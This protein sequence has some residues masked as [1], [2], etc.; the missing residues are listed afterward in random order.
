MNRRAGGQSDS[1]GKSRSPVSARMRWL[2]LLLALLPVLLVVRL[3]YEQNDFV[4]SVE[5]RTY[6][7]RFKTLRGPVAAHPGVA[8]IAV[9]DKSIAAL[10]RF[11]WTRKEYVRLLEALERA[12]PKVVLFDAFFPEP[13]SADADRAFA[14]ALQKAGNVVLATAFDFDRD[15]NVTGATRSLPQFEESAAAAHINLVPEDDGVNRRNLLAI[16]H[17]GE[18]VPSLGFMAALRALDVQDVRPGSDGSFELLDG[19]GKVLRRVPVTPDGAVWINYAGGAGVYE[20]ISFVD[21]VEGRFD[22][23]QLAGKAVFVGATALGIYDMRVT[24]FSVNA[25][26][27]E[28]HAAVAD[29]ILSSRVMERGSREA[30]FDLAAIVLL[31]LLCSA[32]AMRLRL[33]YA[34]V[35]V[36]GFVAL[37]FALA[38]KLFAEGQWVSMV[39]PAMA[40]LATLMTGGA[41]RFMVIERNARQMRAMF[42]TY[43]SNKLVGQLEQNPDAARLG[44]DTREVTVMFTDIKGFTTFSERHPP[45]V[46][47]ERL[48]EYLGAMVQI[49]HRHDGTVDKFMGDGILAY[50]GAPLPQDGH[51]QLALSCALAMRE[52]MRK[53]T[54]QWERH[55]VPA[56]TIRGGIQS[57]PVVA[58]NIGSRGLK[59]EYTVIGDTVNQASRFEGAGK[60]Y[61]VDFTVGEATVRATAGAFRFRSLDR[62]RVVGKEQPVELYELRASYTDGGGSLADPL[63]DE[64]ADRFE[65]ALS[66]YRA[67]RWGDAAS[68]LQVILKQFPDDGPSRLYLQRCGEF[69]RDPPG[70]EWDGVFNRTD[71]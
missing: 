4:E 47:V 13:E 48:N 8:V 36:L 46:V 20:R 55:D 24:P 54:A 40:A 26:G 29:G 66:L 56:F 39:Y 63:A 59:M 67:Q 12:K 71:K 25:P 33:P 52:Q 17:D 65:A 21:V 44:G 15:F 30:W 5:A 3:Y 6:D 22:P 69:L 57:G 61:G 60:T 45:E 51:A 38:E 31:G 34:I 50:W 62:V 23:V 32:L 28:V 7:L 42:S 11:P 37:H 16:E 2:A 49:I 1:V 58:G 68:L 9:D 64:L 35:F 14:R 53:L 43:V 70:P 19:E 41:W 27:V 18:V 10:G